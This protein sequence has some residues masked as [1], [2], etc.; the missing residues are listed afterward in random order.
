MHVCGLCAL[1]SSSYNY[2][3]GVI[4]L[5]LYP[6]YDYLGGPLHLGDIEE[7]PGSNT[8]TGSECSPHIIC[9]WHKWCFDLSTGRQVRPLGRHNDIETFPVRTDENGRIFIGFASFDPSCFMSS[10]F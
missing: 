2:T 5:L 8:G 7:L 9:P 1:E 3:I 10:D 6:L 4:D